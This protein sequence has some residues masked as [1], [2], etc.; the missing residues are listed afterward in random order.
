[1]SSIIIGL[2][3][4]PTIVRCHELCLLKSSAQPHWVDYIVRL[5]KT[6]HQWLLVGRLLM[7]DHQSKMCRYIQG[8]PKKRIPRFILGI[9]SVIQH[10]F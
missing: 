1:M 4:D 3:T 5:Q 6:F 7:N 10:R 2:T 9:T 8:G